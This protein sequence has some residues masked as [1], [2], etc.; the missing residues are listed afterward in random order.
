MAR[1]PQQTTA[2][3]SRVLSI[4]ALF[5][6]GRFEPAR[7]QRD[8]QWE[9]P[10]W[11][12]LL[13]DFLSAFRLAGRDPD[14]QLDT[15][16]ADGDE[17]PKDTVT[18]EPIAPA[19]AI[20]QTPRP[21]GLS[22][23][24]LGHVLLHP[25]PQAAEQYLIYDGQQRFTTLT[26]LLCALRDA[27][28]QDGEW[29]AIQEVLRTP[30]PANHPRLTVSTRGSALAGIVDT[31]F[32]TTTPSNVAL[33]RAGQLMVGAARFFLDAIKVWS[34]AR[35]RAFATF[36]LDNVFVTVTMMR[37][38]R[39]VEYAYITINTRGRALE[40]KDIIKGHF[41]QLASRESLTGA[42]EMSDKWAAL[43]RLAGKRLD[44][45]LRTA[46]L[47]DYR[48]P[49]TFDFGAQMMDCFDDESKL[50]EVREWVSVRLPAIVELHKTLILAPAQQG[51]LPPPA[52]SIRRLLFLGWPYWQALALRFAERDVRAPKRFAGSMRALEQWAFSINLLDVED[53]H[54]VEMIVEALDQSDTIDPFGPGGALRLSRNWKERVRSRLQDGQIRDARR[55]GA[56]VR[57][58]ESLYWPASLVNFGATNDS[59]V[60]HV[61]PQRP[62]GQ[63]LADF[64]KGIHISSEQFGNLCLVPKDV[65][66]KLGNQ[67]Y[68][69]KRKAYRALPK[70]FK[71]AHDVAD[72][73]K[74]TIAAVE[75]R[76]EALRLK[77]L[78][79][80][81]LAG[82]S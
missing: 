58:L 28:G 32:G 1:S 7:A 71:S 9:R 66:E 21:G 34:E 26:L 22:H 64:P 78:Q 5:L 63:W 27:A 36:L 47:L 74:W 31:L 69:E 51:V 65:N 53:E 41:I 16:E 45:L 35:R 11:N 72:A 2:P 76:N 8:Y 77:A 68:A 38:R 55:R 42:N 14:A 18:K 48:R 67:Q 57:W 4:R 70:H 37:E 3:E 17:T 75:A 10:Q 50:E 80:L 29:Y 60:E 39:V 54:L 79:A 59:S 6:L 12:D 81:G 40:N 19:R 52:C 20:R 43:E 61:L 49:P 13:L 23:Y 25:R 56:H 46:F 15:G 33:S 24:Y 73:A 82:G 44:E 62:T 30:P